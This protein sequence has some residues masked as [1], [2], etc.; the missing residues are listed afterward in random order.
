ME[1]QSAFNS[2]V[3]GFHKATEDATKAAADIARPQPVRPV[4]RAPCPAQKPP[5][6]CCPEGPNARLKIPLG[7]QIEGPWGLPRPE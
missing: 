4:G 6:R 1:I 5:R 7:H 3:Q 2:G